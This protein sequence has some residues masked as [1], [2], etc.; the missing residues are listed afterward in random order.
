[1][2]TNFQVM[3]PAEFVTI[4]ESL[5]LTAQWIAENSGMK[6][7]TVQFLESGRAEVPEQVS[8]MLD[9]I[10]M[11]LDSAVDQA[12]TAIEKVIEQQGI[13]PSSVALVRYRS[14]A[15]LWRFRP[16]MKPLPTTAHA[17]MLSRL[18][19]FLLSRGIPSVIKFMEPKQYLVW[20]AGRPDTEAERGRWA[21]SLKD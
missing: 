11:M 13:P 12:I 15:D 14:D 4:R 2:K 8:S 17:V 16:D 21:V 10:Y 20:L 9:R 19:C 6:L 1:M 18:R 3:T 5:G 7:R